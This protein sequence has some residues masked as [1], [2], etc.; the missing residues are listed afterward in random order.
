[1]SKPLLVYQA[2]VFTRSG[3]GDHARDILRSLFDLDKYDIKIVPTRWGNTPQ[4]Q[5]DPTTEF[6][7]KMLT[8]V[9]TQVNRKPDIFI[10]MSVAN[11]FEPK[12]NFNIGITAGVETTVIPKEFIDGANKMDLIIVPSQFTKSLFDKTQYQEQDK[13]SGQVIRTFKTEKP[14]EVL[15]EGVD[16]D[17]Y[18]NYPKSENDILEGI[19]TNFNFLF[20]GHW[21]KGKLGQDRKDVGMVI[22]TFA[23][24]FKYLPKDKRP[25]LILKTS[26]AGFSV[27]DRETTREKIENVIKE[28]GDDVPPIYLLHGDLKD[29]EM[30]ELYNHSKVKAMVS[31]TKGEGYGRPLAEFATTGKP[32]IVSKWSGHVDFLP[33]PHT[34]FLDGQ[35]TDVDNSAADKFLLKE[36]K[37]FTVNYSNAANKLYQVFN[38][39]DSFSK[40]SSGL[41]PNIVNNFTMEKMTEVLGKLMDNYVGNVPVQKAFN[42]PKL[43]DNKLKLPKLNTQPQTPELKIPK[44]NKI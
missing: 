1:M 6:G 20:V 28:L 43:G 11:E 42:L 44:L 5:A 41:K 3:Y 18:I 21:L 7:Q 24:V 19:E 13:Q 31:F 27:I 17:T 32:I 4:N 16:I 26:H 38:E 2:P 35:L 8:N 22:K 25:G 36:S 23:T 29:T 30:A 37:W 34:V 40:Q 14:V 10:Q 9:A 12:G 15:F 33:E 39:Y